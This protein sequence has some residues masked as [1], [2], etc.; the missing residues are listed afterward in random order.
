MPDA[1]EGGD[2]LAQPPDED[3]RR[4]LRA[5]R[6]LNPRPERVTDELFRGSEPF[7][8]PE[9]LVQVKYEMLRRVQQDKHTVVDAARS[10]G[11]SRPAFYQTQQVF[12]KRGLPG[13]VHQRPG[14]RRR[15][16]LTEEVLG[17]L[18]QVQAEQPDVS[19]RQLVERV[20]E[21]FGLQVHPRTI[22][23]ALQGRA[24]GGHSL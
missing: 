8:D 23:R 2:R 5:A 18:R 19:S 9:D 11:F 14:P 10:F 24:K 22:E 4:E 3:K 21:R 12:Q 17:F 16:K 6:A 13:L 15:H 20:R 7:F 1:R